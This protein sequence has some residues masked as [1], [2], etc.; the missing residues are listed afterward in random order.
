MSTKQKFGLGVFLT[1]NVWLIIIALVWVSLFK[2]GNNFDLTWTLFMQF[3]EPNI[4]ILAA[5]FSA[6]RSVFVKNDTK[7]PRQ[8]RPTYSLRQ[9]VFR[10]TLPE[11]Q[12]LDDLTIPE[13]E[14]TSMRTM[15]WKNN[16]TNATNITGN[17]TTSSPSVDEATGDAISER[18]L[19]AHP[20]RIKVKHGWSLK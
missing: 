14:L 8:D 18:S 10:R 13:A 15:I 9:R 16:A 6:F 5:S 20:N 19:V 11:E 12:Q 3:F 2:V 17:G 7:E 1:L 4:A